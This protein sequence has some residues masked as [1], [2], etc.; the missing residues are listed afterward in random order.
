MSPMY[1]F[2]QMKGEHKMIIDTLTELIGSDPDTRR[3]RMDDLTVQ[4]MTHMRAEERVLYLAF[5]GL[6]A[7]PRSFAERLGEE[8][9]VARMIMNELGE[10]GVD[11][12][13]WIAKLQVL[14]SLLERHMASEHGDLADMASD[15]FGEEEIDRISRDYQRVERDLFTRA[16]IEPL[17]KF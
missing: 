16:R 13:H 14:R 6:D 15:Y 10:R 7:V 17:I 9:H 12:E 5:E 4:I 2:D 1:V 3:D 8:H 11:N